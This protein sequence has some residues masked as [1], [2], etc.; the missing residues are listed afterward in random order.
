MTWFPVY[1]S[2]FISSPVLFPRNQTGN[3]DTPFITCHSRRPY[4]AAAHCT[5]AG[6]VEAHSTVRN[7]ASECSCR[8]SI[9]GRRL[10]EWGHCMILYRAALA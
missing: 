8:G 10:I 3:Y 5:G 7:L 4:I 6:H 2:D 9:L 1:G